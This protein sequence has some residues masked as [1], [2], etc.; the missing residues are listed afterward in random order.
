MLGVPFATTPDTAMAAWDEVNG[1][2]PP[3]APLGGAS[4]DQFVPH[5]DGYPITLKD[6]ISSRLRFRK[7]PSE[8]TGFQAEWRVANRSFPIP[9]GFTLGPAV[10]RVT[11]YFHEPHMTLEF[12]DEARAFH[13]S[14]QG[15]LNVQ[16]HVSREK[17]DTQTA[18]RLGAAP[19]HIGVLAA[20]LLVYEI[21][22]GV[23][24]NEALEGRSLKVTKDHLQRAFLLLKLAG[25][26]ASRNVHRL[27]DIALGDLASDPDAVTPTAQELLGSVSAPW[28][29]EDFASFPATQ[30]PPQDDNGAS[31]HDAP[32]APN[33]ADSLVAA[34]ATPTVENPPLALLTSKD[35][36]ALDYGY[37]H[38][39]SSVQ[40]NLHAPR[41]TDRFIVRH[42]L[43]MGTPKMDAR[44]ACS[45][46]R[47]AKNEGKK[48]LPRD[49]WMIVMK[50]ASDQCSVIRLQENDGGSVSLALKPPPSD[51]DA[52]IRYHNDLMQL[53]G[54]SLREL[55]DAMA[56]AQKAACENKRKRKKED[57]DEEAEDEK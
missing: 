13:L 31:D 22:C 35:V 53:C 39:G 29:R 36:R 17:G 1:D 43:L 30:P 6:G 5:A 28:A 14:Y 12:D 18:A 21:F 23:H 45:R 47:S 19:W 4:G 55:T 24:G 56:K 16:S 20:L 57:E 38:D 10:A 2:E 33:V 8:P 48:A 15:G 26:L 52:R 27:E 34:P 54:L 9:E 46:L 32:R 7:D 44:E 3:P 11:T 37:G 40:G 50:A 25:C 49:K 42:T 41:L 51:A